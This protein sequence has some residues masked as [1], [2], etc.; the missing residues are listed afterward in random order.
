MKQKAQCSL[1]WI[2]LKCKEPPGNYLIERSPI[3]CSKCIFSSPL[4]LAYRSLSQRY[5]S[6]SHAPCG[7]T[8]GQCYSEDTK[9]WTACATSPRERGWLPTDGRQ[10]QVTFPWLGMALPYWYL[11]I[12]YNPLVGQFGKCN[13]A[14]WSKHMWPLRSGPPSVSC[15]CNQLCPL[16]PK[17]NV[18]FLHFSAQI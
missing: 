4:Q 2:P 18:S 11:C 17:L 14:N 10:V 15:C 6:R 7:P 3:F 5:C 9:G 16:V 1:V 12:L 8:L 13:K